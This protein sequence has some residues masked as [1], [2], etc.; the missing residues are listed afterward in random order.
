MRSIIEW[1]IDGVEACFPPLR[2]RRA[3][4]EIDWRWALEA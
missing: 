2:R 4:R 3:A 1:I